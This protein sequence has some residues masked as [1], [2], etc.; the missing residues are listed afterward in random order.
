[1]LCTQNKDRA[2][3]FAFNS[4]PGADDSYEEF[5]RRSDN[6]RSISFCRACGRCVSDREEGRL[7]NSVALFTRGRR[8]I[9]CNCNRAIF[10]SRVRNRK[11]RLCPHCGHEMVAG[12]SVA[13][14]FGFGLCW[15]LSRLRS[16]LQNSC[17]LFQ[18]QPLV[19]VSRFVPPW[20]ATSCSCLPKISEHP[21]LRLR[22]RARC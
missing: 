3:E 16:P 22:Y 8:Y 17:R 10:K 4:L 2:L 5:A 18:Q 13:M 11:D 6:R 1:M 21:S 12:R 7:A 9:C 19:P 14:A 15:F 20:P